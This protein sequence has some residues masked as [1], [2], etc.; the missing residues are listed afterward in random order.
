MIAGFIAETNLSG[1][2]GELQNI[3]LDPT[4]VRLLFVLGVWMNGTLSA[5]HRG[6]VCNTGTSL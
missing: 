3:L 1:V 6:H 2:A 5:L 4:I